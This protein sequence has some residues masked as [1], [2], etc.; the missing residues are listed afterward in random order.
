M[1]VSC[2]TTA[3]RHQP[4]Y[5]GCYEDEDK[6]FKMTR[7]SEKQ[8]RNPDIANRLFDYQQRKSTV[9]MKPHVSLSEFWI[10]VTRVFGYL[11]L[12][13]WPLISRTWIFVC[14][15]CVTKMEYVDQKNLR[16]LE[17]WMFCTRTDA[18]QFYMLKILHPTCKRAL[19]ISLRSKCLYLY[20][21]HSSV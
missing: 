17:F 5:P 20:A 12:H 4:L 7:S 16:S 6:L 13:E 2:A 15:V 14:L 8:W 10:L 21:Q 18:K 9:S 3:S 19:R 1:Q 11:H